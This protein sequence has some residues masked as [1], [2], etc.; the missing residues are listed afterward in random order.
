MG[1]LAALVS[2]CIGPPSDQHQ[3]LAQRPGRH[4]EEHT[5]TGGSGTRRTT[6]RRWT[7]ERIKSTR[8]RSRTL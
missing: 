8:A 3:R 1:N 4:R 7:R 2:G 6:S 5:A